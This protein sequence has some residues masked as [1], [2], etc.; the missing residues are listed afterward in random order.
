MT[1]LNWE[2]AA[3]RDYVAKHGSVSSWVDLGSGEGRA[4]AREVAMRVRLQAN[5]S[6]VREYADLTPLERQSRYQSYRQRLFN[7]FDDERSRIRSGDTR[8]REAIDEYEAGLLSL[9]RGLRPRP[10]R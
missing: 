9:L 10:D 8:L 3:K 4:E 5:L 1:K 7:R 6:V 2:E